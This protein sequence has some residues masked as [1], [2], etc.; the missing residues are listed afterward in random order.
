[1]TTSTK[2]LS[3]Q[4]IK[5]I[6]T[7]KNFHEALE[8]DFVSMSALESKCCTDFRLGTSPLTTIRKYF[9]KY[10][11]EIEVVHRLI[12]NSTQKLNPKKGALQQ[13]VSHTYH[14]KLRKQRYYKNGGY[15]VPCRMQSISVQILRHQI[16][17]ILILNRCGAIKLVPH[18]NQR[19]YYE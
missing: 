8:Q 15:P 2:I 19:R 4:E 11:L 13:T 12:N 10:G 6:L 18:H 14:I 17:A 16:L 3:D 5:N 7:L 1:M 9:S